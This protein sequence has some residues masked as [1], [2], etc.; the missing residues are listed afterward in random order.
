MSL[1]DP[2]I[3]YITI[4]DAIITLLEANPDTLNTGITGDVKQII[5]ANPITHPVPSTM[6]PTVFVMLK[7]NTEEFKTIGG[8]RK[9]SILHFSIFGFVRKLTSDKDSDDEMMIFADNIQAV[10][11]DN[12]NINSAVAMAGPVSCDFGVLEIKGGT[13]VSGAEI[14]LDCL[15]R[16]Q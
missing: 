3:Q 1:N 5:G 11:R 10:F 4:R 2:R 13:Y 9:E 15:V 7:N 6:Y 14:G 8:G 12:I 16:L